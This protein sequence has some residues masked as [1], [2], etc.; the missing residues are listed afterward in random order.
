MKPLVTARKKMLNI[1][2]KHRFDTALKRRVPNAADSINRVNDEVLM[3]REKPVGK[4]VGTYLVYRFLQNDKSFELG[5]GDRLIIASIGKI[6]LYQSR[7]SPTTMTLSPGDN[8]NGVDALVKLG[9]IWR[10][11]IP[12]GEE[13]KSIVNDIAIPI[14][15]FNPKQ[16]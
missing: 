13:Q 14:D 7:T 2:A 9:K 6:T 5:T 10:S 11:Y 16:N 3:F 15:A 12:K 8:K 4:W 1:V